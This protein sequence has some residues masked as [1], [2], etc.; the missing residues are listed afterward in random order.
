MGMGYYLILC[1]IF[2]FVKLYVIWTLRGL[3][4]A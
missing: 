4:I 1:V 3:V 2:R